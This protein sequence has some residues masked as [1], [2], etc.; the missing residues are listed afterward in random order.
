MASDP[1]ETIE[2]SDSKID[3]S[4]LSYDFDHNEIDK[5]IGHTYP[6]PK[7]IAT[8]MGIT[9][10]E[11][12][13]LG[14]LS[15]RR[16]LQ[17]KLFKPGKITMSLLQ[18]YRKYPY[19]HYTIRQKLELMEKHKSE[20]PFKLR[21]IIEQVIDD[22]WLWRGNPENAFS[23]I[24]S[25]VRVF[26]LGRKVNGGVVDLSDS[27]NSQVDTDEEVELLMHC[28]GAEIDS[29]PH[30]FFYHCMLEMMST[31]PQ[32][33]RFVPLYI[34]MRG[35]P[36]GGLKSK[37]GVP[38]SVLNL[39]AGANDNDLEDE[40][41]DAFVAL[42]CLLDNLKEPMNGENLKDMTLRV[43]RAGKKNVSFMRLLIRKRPSL[44]KRCRNGYTLIHFVV[45]T[46]PGLWRIVD[47][48][49][50]HRDFIWEL[51]IVVAELGLQYYPEDL[52]FIFHG[53]NYASSCTLW[54][55]D[56][57]ERMVSDKIRKVL[58]HSGTGSCYSTMVYKAAINEDISLD[59]VY[60]L[61]RI[62]PAAAITTRLQQPQK[63]NHLLHGCGSTSLDDCG[64]SSLADCGSTSLDDCGSSSLASGFVSS[65][66]A[67]GMLIFLL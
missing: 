52:G 48:D 14:D 7:D 31:E 41:S 45:L 59:G 34:R 65:A 54:E 35:M 43:L 46:I 33:H 38:K 16:E 44:L 4:S 22:N 56:R 51:Y 61:L 23:I 50:I 29:S 9:V 49:V 67:V 11:V 1:N 64:S 28:F 60:T 66:F 15:K 24:E 40:T 53:I 26:F 19:L 6:T 36:Y 58:H 37:S 5:F 30:N 21:P 2:N 55:Q 8:E 63:G 17:R 20:F 18:W 10:L 3:V 42:D 25:N 57:V 62:D 12:I 47:R 13:K 32:A 39:L 27:L